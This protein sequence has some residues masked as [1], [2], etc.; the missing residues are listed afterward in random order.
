M[1]SLIASKAGKYL[2]GA[3]LVIGIIAAIY[4]KGKTEC[5]EEVLIQEQREVLERIE[6]SHE[7][8]RE[9]R[10]FKDKVTKHRESNPVDDARDSCLLSS[11]RPSKDCGEYLQD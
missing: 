8:V 10:K 1:F 11:S 2:I 5:R 4:W 7:V 9:E 3:L 6:K